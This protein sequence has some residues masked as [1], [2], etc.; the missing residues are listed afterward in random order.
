MMQPIPR[1]HRRITP[2]E[3][4]IASVMLMLASAC[5]PAPPCPKAPAT[6]DLATAPP[7]P[8]TEE[9]PVAEQASA[10]KLSYA[11]VLQGVSN[12]DDALAKV[13]AA[14]KA[15]GFGVITEIDM[16]ATMKKKLDVQMRP[17]WIL[18]A[19]SPKKAYRAIQ[20]DPQMGLL[21]PCK[22]IV[23][24]TADGSFTVAFARPEAM[25]SLAGRPELAPLAKEVDDEFRGAFDAL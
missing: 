23:Y 3:L 13:K 8:P 20:A 24:Q 2:V 22:V 9:A 17:F 5:A 21:L 1:P 11:K 19:C 12:I 7:T 10:P 4:G 14:L 16:Q 15:H 18:G 6:S 25:F